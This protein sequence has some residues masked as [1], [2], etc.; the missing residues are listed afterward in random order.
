MVDDWARDDIASYLYYKGNI[1]IF[2]WLQP[3]KILQGMFAFPR[4]KTN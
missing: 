3:R 1:K 2:C 4:I